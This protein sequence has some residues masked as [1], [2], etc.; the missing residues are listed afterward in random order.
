MYNHY[1]YGYQ[2]EIVDQIL[3]TDLQIHK[4]DFIMFTGDHPAIY[5]IQ[6]VL[7]IKSES[8]QPACHNWVVNRMTK[9]VVNM[10]SIDTTSVRP[11]LPLKSVQGYTQK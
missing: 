5:Q 10:S 1:F 11:S 4:G 7:H 9:L 2:G 3:A 8:K 6:G